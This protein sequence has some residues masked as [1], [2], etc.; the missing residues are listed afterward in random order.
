MPVRARLAAAAVVAACLL[1]APSGAQA[2]RRPETGSADIANPHGA[3]SLRSVAGG[4][5]VQRLKAGAGRTSQ[6]EGD[7]LLAIDGTPVATPEAIM[8][9]LRHQ[10]EAKG[11]DHAV[12]LTVRR[13][14]ETLRLTE[15]AALFHDFMTPEPPVPS[16]RPAR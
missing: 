2:E 10:G 7:V 9:H 6:R 1:V 13:G 14:G 15:R 8:A 11:E 12:V 3:L 4:V 5:V 16:A